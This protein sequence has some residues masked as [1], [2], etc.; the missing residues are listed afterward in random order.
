MPASTSAPRNVTAA[1]ALVFALD[2]A[3]AAPPAAPPAACR[4]RAR[5]AAR[6][7]KRVAGLPAAAYGGHKDVNQACVAST[8][9]VNVWPAAAAEG[10]QRMEMPKKTSPEDAAKQINKLL[11]ELKDNSRLE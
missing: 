9:V 5:Q 2:A 7:G 10:S 1:V 3:A 4:A 6:R 11:G 8:L